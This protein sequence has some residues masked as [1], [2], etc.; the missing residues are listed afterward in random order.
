M[1]NFRVLVVDDSVVARR[2]IAA[3]LSDD[4]DIEVVG[5]ASNGE[6][7]LTKIDLLKPDLVT[8]DLEMPIMS[9]LEVLSELR[10]K[11]SRVPV[12]MF[13]SLTEQGAA[14][15]LEALSLGAIDYVTKPSHVGRIADARESVA[16][17]LIPRIKALCTKGAAPQQSSPVRLKPKSPA[18]A[19][20]VDI[21]AIGVSTGGPKALESLLSALPADLPVPMVVVQH[22]P[23][24]FTRT[25]AQSLEAK[26]PLQ[27]REGEAGAELQP[28]T[29]WI[30][31][32]DF[33]MVVERAGE[34]VLLRTHQQ[35]PVN[36]CR[37]SVDTLFQSV[38]QVYGANTLAVVMTGMGQDGLQGCEEIAQRGG[39]VVAQD[40]A[41][42]VVWGMPSFI[43]NAELADAILP[44]DEI[45][46]NIISHV[47][48]GRA[49]GRIPATESG[50]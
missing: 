6:I 5:T 28:G 39:Q 21:V 18:L 46:P 24:I 40:E 35:P 48:F 33:H 49:P 4:P 45:A 12:V 14:A 32:G 22:M 1:S 34:K 9:G 43:A 15:T 8:L 36:S 2:L 7:A 25:L 3:A 17:S 47:R 38:V 16:A 50:S 29:V 42:S 10:R 37:P 27:I 20:R 31:P 41:T 30:A 19:Q 44:L 26:S 13:S 11:K 23:A